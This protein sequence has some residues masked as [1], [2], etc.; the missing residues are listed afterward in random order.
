MKTNYNRKQIVEA[1][2]YWQHILE[3]MSSDDHTVI[4]MK[5]THGGTFYNNDT[6]ALEEKYGFSYRDYDHADEDS[7]SG[8][9]MLNGSRFFSIKPE[10]KIYIAK[11]YDVLIH[12]YSDGHSPNGMISVNGHD[13]P[14]LPGEFDDGGIN[15]RWFRGYK[16]ED[17]A[18]QRFC[19]FTSSSIEEAKHHLVQ[20]NEFDWGF[21]LHR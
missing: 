4:L 13:F 17:A 8:Y 19:E 7:E 16:T 14:A 18:A 10:D 12:L 20:L 5:D 9:I 3:N 1:I 21:R 11:N 6:E 15:C 2:K